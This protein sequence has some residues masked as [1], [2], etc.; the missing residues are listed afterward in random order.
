MYVVKANNCTKYIE[1]SRQKLNKLQQD[2][3]ISVI[4][5]HQ[6]LEGIS[7]LLIIIHQ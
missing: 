4:N 1:R 6:I 7:Y 2:I 5:Q 3:G